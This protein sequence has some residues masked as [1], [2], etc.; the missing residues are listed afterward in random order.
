[1]TPAG[2]APAVQLDDVHV[3]FGARTALAGVNLTVW[4]GE[5]VGLVGPSG[6]G[7]S[8]LLRIINGTAA[9]T[10]GRVVV[11]GSDVSALSAGGLRRLRTGI[12]TVHQQL[13]LVPPLRVVHNVN[14]ARLGS[15]SAFRSLWSLVRPQGV[16][17]VAAALERVGIGARIFDRT[18]ELSGGQQQ[19]VALAR[20][21]VQDPML[22]LADE[23]VSSLDPALARQA[24]SELSGVARERGRTLL[25]S[26]HD[27]AMA[28]AF[29]DRL[30]G[31]R[32]GRISFDVAASM[33]TPDLFDQLYGSPS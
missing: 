26:L 15:W 17:E 20:I 5:C 31:L 30:V 32:D 14:A 22:V 7:K 8:T 28:T 4:P 24:L 9:P 1:M 2:P 25:I 29:C 23:P 16:S 11:A 19:R 18:D 21:L 12:G 27:P 33:A 3:R 13:D 6:A 10:S